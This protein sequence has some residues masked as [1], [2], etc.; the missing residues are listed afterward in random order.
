[1]LVEDSSTGNFSLWHK[2]MWVHC[3]ALAQ[4]I[5]SKTIL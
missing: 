2:G 1:M 4:Q 3:N 5:Q